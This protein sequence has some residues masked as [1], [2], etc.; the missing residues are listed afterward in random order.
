MYIK[1]LNYY[2]TSIFFIVCIII[3]ISF[4]FIFNH[5]IKSNFYMTFLLL[6]DKDDNLLT[7]QLTIFLGILTNCFTPKK[8]EMK[9][10]T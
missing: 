10:K 1:N 5:F 6:G 2:Y 9:K 7:S 3:I 8:K 4:F